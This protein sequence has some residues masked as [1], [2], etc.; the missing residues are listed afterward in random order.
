MTD[1]KETPQQKHIADYNVYLQLRDLNY[2]N[3]DIA[4][5]LNYSN[6]QLGYLI[7]RYTF[8]NSLEYSLQEN[9]GD[10]YFNGK[11]YVTQNASTCLTPDEILEIYTF[12]QQ[13]VKQH[14]GIDYLQS[15]YS[16]EQDCKLF[17]IDNL[18]KSIIESGNYREQDNY[19]T[20]ML[21][22]DY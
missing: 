12:T 13:L 15:F 9:E 8:K 6:E 1:F 20:L 10:Y 17:F 18:S 19:C 21:A 3:T 11:F 2:T 7:S 14:K 16:V 22:S 4:K 5:H